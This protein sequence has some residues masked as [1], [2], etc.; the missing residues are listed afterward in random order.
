MLS[1]RLLLVTPH[2]ENTSANTANL[3]A[4]SVC[5]RR[6]QDMGLHVLGDWDSPIMPIMVY[7]LCYIS[8]I[9][10]RCL[11][12]HIA[13][14]VVGFPATALLMSRCRVC[15]SASHTKEDL[16]YAL[17][18][19]YDICSKMGLQYAAKQMP[20][21]WC[22]L[23]LLLWPPALGNYRAGDSSGCEKSSSAS[24][25]WLWAQLFG[26]GSGKGGKAH[27]AAAVAA[28]KAQPL[29]TAAA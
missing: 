20:W 29:V 24:G 9:S 4:A 28:G 2:N 13:M 12:R 5:R 3:P 16:D 10:R 17:E 14:V 26:K 8:G 27:S 21:P 7:H 15:I 19:I 1:L 18:V 11:Q 6:L 22:W 23:R 25:S